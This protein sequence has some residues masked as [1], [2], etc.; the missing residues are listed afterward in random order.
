MS[1]QNNRLQPIISPATIIHIPATAV[2]RI[3]ILRAVVT[4]TM[5]GNWLP[6]NATYFGIL[7]QTGL[8][9]AL[10][11][12]TLIWNFYHTLKFPAK[13]YLKTHFWHLYVCLGSLVCKSNAQILQFLNL[14]FSFNDEDLA[15]VPSSLLDLAP[16][17]ERD[18]MLRATRHLDRSKL[19][20]ESIALINLD[21]SLIISPTKNEEM[22]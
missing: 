8:P 20:E 9:R 12:V 16:E 10:K 14:F 1:A 5:M 11:Q 3:F 4:N 2:G 18:Q 15:A 7:L 22:R 6:N 21:D 17:W 13:N 19:S